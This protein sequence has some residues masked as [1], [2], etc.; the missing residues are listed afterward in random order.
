MA[1]D[2]QNQE[3]AAKDARREKVMGRME[4]LGIKADDLWQKAAALDLGGNYPA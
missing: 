1:R 4:G 3:L 2:A